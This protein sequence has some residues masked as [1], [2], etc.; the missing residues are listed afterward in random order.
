MV[1]VDVMGGLPRNAYLAAH[2]EDDQGHDGPED[3]L[4]KLHFALRR[5][6]LR[7]HR[8]ERLDQLEKLDCMDPKKEEEE[9]NGEQ[10]GRADQSLKG[11][12]RRRRRRRG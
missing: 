4:A 6:D 8:H 2:E 10:D 11:T 7:D 9:E 12:G 5:R 1:S 3:L